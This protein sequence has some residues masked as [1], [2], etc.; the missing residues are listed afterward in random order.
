MTQ[1]L[2][3]DLE[4]KLG[5]RAVH[6]GQVPDPLSG[7]VMT[8]IYQTST[9]IQEGLGRHKGYEYA[10]THNPTRE[11]LERNVAAPRGRHATASPSARGSRRSTPCSSCSRAATTSSAARTC[12]AAATASWSGSTPASA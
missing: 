3:H 7:A 8:P 1:I 4:T 10:R 12:T 5:T 9:Y 2:P 6:A 11:A